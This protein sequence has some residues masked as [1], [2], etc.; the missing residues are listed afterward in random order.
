MPLSSATG[1]FAFLVAGTRRAWYNKTTVQ[2]ES[3]FAGFEVITEVISLIECP[4]LQ[5]IPM[6]RVV[7]SA[8]LIRFIHWPAMSMRWSPGSE[9][10][11]RNESS[12]IV[13]G[14]V[15][16]Q[17]IDGRRKIAPPTH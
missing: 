15:V 13:E 16:Y 3:S 8:S 9:P 17:T 14:P 7:G 1:S 6:D 10:G 11:D 2:G 5:A 4:Q 12:I